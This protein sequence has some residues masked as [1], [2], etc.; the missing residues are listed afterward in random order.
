VT[1]L[2][3]G[4]A[5]DVGRIRKI[6]QDLPLERAN[7]YAV[8][9]GMGGH[10]GGEVAAR[11]AVETLQQAFERT[12]TTA[13]LRAAFDEANLEVWRQSQVDPDLRGMGT[14][15]TAMALVGGPGGHDTLTLA[16]VGDS[17]AYV[18]SGGSLV[19]VTDD[20]S[21][22]E[23]RMRH[24]EMTEAEAAVHP[25][26]H[27]LTRA[28]G[29]SS[30][31]EPDMWELELHAGDRVL[32]C[33]DGLSN[34]LGLDEM[35]AVLDEV[36]DPEAAARRL[37]DVANDHGGADNITVVVVDVQIGE[38]GGS[39][40]VVTPIG[41]DAAAASAA[42]AAAAAAATSRSTE[43]DDGTTA[44][45][46][47]ESQS[48]AAGGTS[49][50]AEAAAGPLAPGAHL[51]FGS[52]DGTMLAE[53]GPHSGEFFLGNTVAAP[54]ARS[55]T[56]VPLAPG[57]GD[58]A[59]P[60]EQEQ[61]EKKPGKKSKKKKKESRGARRR[62]L[63]IPRRV[64]PRVLGFLLLVI[65]VPVAAYLVLRWYAYDNYIVTLQGNQIVVKQGQPGG[66]LWFHPRVVDHTGVTT[67]QIL[68][69]AVPA[70]RAGVQE[71]SLAAAHT[72]VRQ[73]RS[74]ATATTTTT[75]TTT[76]TSTTGAAG[77]T[78][79]TS[80]RVPAGGAP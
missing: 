42:G 4:S 19:Q 3:S 63:G 46:G 43:Q 15:L 18:F 48:E 27:I 50:V 24:G 7:L 59:E 45:P 73:L 23:E 72:Y 35:A 75:T 79:T 55:T 70:V 13:G 52:G 51:S 44:A 69:G 32:I 65:A 33:S 12:P 26:R 9:D 39:V 80:S 41:A 2:R 25:Q 6:N 30:E 37:V 61:P 53:S 58:E 56:P 16:N 54:L 1:V 10:A 31:V 28:L 67:S 78:T 68:P 21:L 5:T 20:H 34:E 71:S 62:R 76:T 11:V 77:V 40:P 74:A 22:A 60:E 47:E 38:R 57:P 49:V 29:V 36:N 64:T 14:T 66:V 17:R 8:A